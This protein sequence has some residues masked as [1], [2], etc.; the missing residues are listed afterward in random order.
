[1]KDLGISLIIMGSVVVVLCSSIY[2]GQR[3][4]LLFT[5]LIMATIIVLIGLIIFMI[6]RKQE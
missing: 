2:V 3:Y 6:G 4:G 1:M 5:V